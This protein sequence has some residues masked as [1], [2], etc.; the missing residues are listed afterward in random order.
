MK[1]NIEVQI[2]ESYLEHVELGDDTDRIMKYSQIVTNILDVYKVR[3][4]KR[5]VSVV[6]ETMTACYKKLANKKNLIS[7]IVMDEETL[8]LKYINIDGNEVQKS[9]L[10]AG[11]KQL[12]VISL[13]WAI[14]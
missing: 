2:V 13:L 14:I 4:Q 5:K 9:S 10:S 3:L 1:K 8:D 7:H 6:A 11:E 12:M